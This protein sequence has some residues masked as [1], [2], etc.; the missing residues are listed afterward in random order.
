MQRML[1]VVV[2]IVAAAAAAGCGSSS[3]NSAS[4]CG[5]YRRDVV[6][7][8]GSHR[9]AAESA[10]TPDERDR[11][12]GGR[13]CIGANQGMLWTFKLPVHISFWMKG[14]KFPIDIVWIG[15]DHRVVWVARNVSPATYPRTFKN[16]RKGALYVVELQAGR[17]KSLGITL[18]TTVA[19]RG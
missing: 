13:H 5:T 10:V 3:G 19:F 12:L 14:M 2:V 17:A 8:I 11:G 15:P 18:G 7:R 16:R 6:L 1:A 9:I 4:S